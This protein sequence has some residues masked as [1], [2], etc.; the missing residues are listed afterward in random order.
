[1]LAGVSMVAGAAYVAGRASSAVALA[2]ARRAACTDELTGLANRAGLRAELL[3][4]AAG[5]DPYAVALVDLDGFKAVN[6][7]YG[8][9]V[10]DAML[11]EVGRRLARLV[12]GAGVAA[13]LGG[14][15][16]VLVAASPAPGISVLLGRDVTR[17]L[18][19]PVYVAGRPVAVRASVG[20]AHGVRG[21]APD[22]LLRAADVAMYR[23][24]TSGVGVVEYDPAEAPPP[25]SRRPRVR[26]REITGLG[27]RL[28]ETRKT[29][30]ASEAVI[31]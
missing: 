6:D 5:G 29:S 7:R 20:V 3:R 26:L 24:K 18:A 12:A 8:H 9:A 11:V 2:Q 10:G 14:D 4:R 1:V 31:A 25:V 23:A 21:D 22:R 17:A 28:S 16:F 19:E 27:R 15:E 13:R 30:K